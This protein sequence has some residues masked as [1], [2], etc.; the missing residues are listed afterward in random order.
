MSQK[1]W[2]SLAELL[3]STTRRPEERKIGI[4][5]E[6]L[7][8]WEDG[9]ALHYRS[10][11]GPR[12]EERLG[13]DSLLREL[14]KRYKWPIVTSEDGEPL[15]FSAPFGK[16]SLEPGSQL[17]LS[18]HASTDL[19]THS[20]LVR[21][22]EAQVDEITRPWGLKWVGLGVN[23]ASRVE[24]IDVIPSTRYH[25]MTDYLGKRARLGTS[26]MRLTTSVQINL[27][28]TSEEEGI[29]MLRA[30]LAAT[31]V[32]YALFANSPIA[33]GAETGYLSY[34]SAIWRETDPDRTGLLPEVFEDG[35][36]FTGYAKL[37]WHRPLMFAQD[38]NQHYVPGEGVSLAD[39]AAGK[40]KGLTADDNNRL[41]GIR[42]LF[43]EARLK[44]GYVEVR[45]IDGLRVADRYAAVAF[46]I[47]LLYSREAR[48]TALKHCSAASSD[49]REKLFLAATR[50]GLSA[51]A[52]RCGLKALA[53]ELVN[54]AR[55]TL[56]S[57]GYGEEKFLEPVVQTIEEELNPAQR[58][59]KEWNGSWKR[60]MAQLIRY[61]D[62]RRV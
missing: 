16:I 35:F 29:E 10:V 56:K 20:E 34:R 42:E 52:G 54:I 7:G 8:I 6:R 25:I 51:K 14:K 17:E 26:M 57:R 2:E 30:A 22:F 36:D 24:E 37:A 32:S 28:Y 21:Q 1:G 41:N 59:L 39:I 44:P 13:A 18:A 61:A 47:G 15:G 50:E 12:G 11:K 4:E 31:P 49:D 60:E 55:Q 5:I 19:F 27:D 40:R 53:K 48:L 23:P 62:D 46:W 9:Q 43:T 33:N 3:R 58:I 45:N 38:G